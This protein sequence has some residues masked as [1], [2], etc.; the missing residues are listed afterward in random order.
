MEDLCAQKM[1][2]SYIVLGYFL[3]LVD[4]VIFTFSPTSVKMRE[5]LSYEAYT[6]PTRLFG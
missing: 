4:S 3:Y 1:Q 6:K 5:S 2:L